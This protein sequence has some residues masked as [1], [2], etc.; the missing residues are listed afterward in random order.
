[1]KGIRLGCTLLSLFALMASTASYAQ[2]NNEGN[3][4]SNPRK[5]IK[6]P[7]P[8]PYIDTNVVQASEKLTI[9]LVGEKGDEDVN[10]DTI[11]GRYDSNYY[12]FEYAARIN[13]FHRNM[14]FDYYN[15][16]YTNLYWY[17]ADPF[18]FGTSIYF[19]WGFPHFG[20]YSC[21]RYDPFWDSFFYDPYFG[22]YGGYYSYWG[23]GYYN[24]IYIYDPYYPYNPYYP[25]YPGSGNGGFGGFRDYA[26]LD[27]SQ[28]GGFGHGS[29]ITS[30]NSGATTEGPSTTRRHGVD[31]NN[32]SGS[33]VSANTVTAGRATAGGR[34][35]TNGRNVA[36]TPVSG[37]QYT[38]PQSIASTRS[39][40]TGSRTTTTRSNYASTSSSSSVSGTR[41]YSAA[42]NTTRLTNRTNS[43]YYNNTGYT[44][45]SS[46]GSYNTSYSDGSR[47]VSSGSYRSSSS[48]S[49]SSGGHSSSSSSSRMSSSSSSHSSSSHSSFSSSGSSHSSGPRR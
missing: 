16:Y 43:G 40:Q 29:Q 25:S 35:Y 20:L 9:Q 32:N 48:S 8:Q 17:T 10:P 22:M 2:Q 44:R 42:D 36:N 13:R 47:T 21:W 30:R 28:L 4:Y 11:Q 37:S 1:M 24:P 26:K 49:Y 19:G 39:A 34:S 41:T 46:R 3:Y 18:F 14:G 38:K 7:K 45:E 23:F 15:D 33:R 6:A 27:H 31:I 5:G 12:D